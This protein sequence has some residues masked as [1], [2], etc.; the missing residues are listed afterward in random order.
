VRQAL[1]G[2][3]SLVFDAEIILNDAFGILLREQT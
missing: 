3:A 2:G 1:R